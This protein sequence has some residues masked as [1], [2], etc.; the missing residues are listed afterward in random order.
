M[1]F[2][3]VLGVGLALGAAS[4]ALAQTPAQL[5]ALEKD[6]EAARVRVGVPGV[7]VA[8]VKNGKVVFSKGFGLRDVDS[9]KPVTPDTLFAVG[10]TTKAFT[11]GCSSHGS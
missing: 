3:R 10:S 11:A 8:I 4:M 9:K 6:I 1:F 5:S 7:S 2:S